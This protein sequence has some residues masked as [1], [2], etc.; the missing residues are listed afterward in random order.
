MESGVFVHDLCQEEENRFWE[1]KGLY[2]KP[3]PD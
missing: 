3:F 1:E 2:A